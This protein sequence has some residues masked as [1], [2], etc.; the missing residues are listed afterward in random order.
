MLLFWCDARCQAVA[1]AERK[2]DDQGCSSLMG[3]DRCE[4]PSSRVQQKGGL[5]GE[6]GAQAENVYSENVHLKPL[7]LKRS[8]GFTSG[9]TPVMAAAPPAEP[10]PVK[11]GAA[12]P[13]LQLDSPFGIGEGGETDDCAASRLELDVIKM[14]EGNSASTSLSY[15]ADTAPL[16]RAYVDPVEIVHTAR[17][18]RFNHVEMFLSVRCPLGQCL[19]PLPGSN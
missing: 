16:K 13:Q 4:P 19:C 1:T 10:P 5:G 2:V 7:K 18:D 17:T 9:A 15:D 14:E 11:P 6:L 12:A 3:E 8:L